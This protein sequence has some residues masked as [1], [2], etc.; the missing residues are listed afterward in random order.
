MALRLGSRLNHGTQH[1]DRTYLLEFTDAVELL[2][3]LLASTRSAYGQERVQA[4]M[5]D[6]L[7]V[8]QADQRRADEAL[9]D[10][11]EGR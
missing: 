7:G 2:V 5:A 9:R 8:S 3:G 11:R 1:D 10:L 6:I 4:A